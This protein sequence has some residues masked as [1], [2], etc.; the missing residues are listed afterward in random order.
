M[1]S[2][3]KACFTYYRTVLSML[4]LFIVFGFYAF[5]TMPKESAPDVKI[6]LISV[7]VNYEGISPQD[8]ERL[9]LRPLE[10][11]LRGLEGVQ[12]LKSYAFE[13][14][15]RVLIKFKAGFDAD[16]ALREARDKSED[17][18]PDLPQDSDRPTVSEINI[19]LFPVL[20]VNL[21]GEVPRR[22]LYEKARELQDAIESEIPAVLEAS[23]RGD[24]E[25]VAEILVDPLA[26]EGYKIS[27]VDVYNVLARNNKL[28]PAGFMD[29]GKGRIGIK[30]P[31]LI[32]SVDQLLN[33]PILHDTKGVVRIKDVAEIRDSFKD[34]DGYARSNGKDAVTLEVSKRTGENI[35]ETVA[36]VK[37]LVTQVTAKWPDNLRV[38]FTQD[39]SVQVKNLLSDLQNNVIAALILVIAVMVVTLGPQS[40][41]LVGIAVPGSFL[42]GV[43]VIYLMGYTLN[44]V[45]LF[46][47]ILSVGI[48]VDGAI[49]VVEY[50]DRKISE[51]LS[52]ADAYLA[53]AQRMFVPVLSS[54]ITVLIVFFPLMFWPGFV[55]QF[56]K[57]L[58]ITLIAVL[59][60][61][62]LMAIIFVPTI[63][64]LMHKIG[65]HP[66]L[67][68]AESIKAL[69]AGDLS[70]ADTLTAW[71]VRVL[72]KALDRPWQTLGWGMLSLV[73]VLML[74]GRFGK[75]I[76][77]F[78]TIEPDQVLV[79]VKARGNYSVREKDKLVRGVEQKIFA[80]KP[81]I[82]T[83]YT[84]TCLTR[85]G[86]KRGSRKPQQITED[87]IGLITLELADWRHRRSAEDIIK[88]LARDLKSFAGLDIEIEKEK[89]GPPTGKSVQIQISS[90]IPQAMEGVVHAVKA[91][92]R[93]MRSLLSHSD[94]L[95]LPGYDWGIRVDREEALKYGADVQT[96][97]SAVR[98]VTNGVKVSSYR[99]DSARDEI[100]IVVRY[101]RIYRNLDQ[102][103]RLRVKT[104]Q[105]LVPISYFTTSNPIPKVTTLR[106]VDGKRAVTLEA[107]VRFGVLASDV[108]HELRVWIAQQPFHKAVQITFKGDQEDQAETGAF[109]VKAFVI[110]LFAMMLVLVT[111]FNSFFS[112]GLILSA[113]MMSSVGVFV[114]L[115]VMNLPFSVV[116]C[117]IGLIALA[118]IIVSNNILLIDTFDGLYAPGK[119][120][121][122]TLLLTGAQRLRPVLLTQITTALGLLPIMLRINIDFLGREITFNAPSSHWWVQLST[123]IVFGIVFASPL[124][125]LMTPCALYLKKKRKKT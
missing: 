43:F 87:T 19:S 51:G 124:T 89:K 9:L 114:G 75:G 30:V 7:D 22:T 84:N 59:S 74:Y 97:G 21:F 63:G 25:R 50:A 118:G 108:I 66:G 78:P 31:G 46:S 68:N 120:L 67:K 123:A 36:Q 115:L 1:G 90:E 38:S 12:E 73:V 27:P 119:D 4:A 47:L 110:A 52:Y 81:D 96:V 104:D 20:V 18:I 121:R 80:Y 83:I 102:L 72:D 23:I 13:G 56:M 24:Q 58:P 45:V 65:F 53:A 109:L 44:I 15:G 11:K 100:D 82:D 8:S 26:L 93:E 70:Q 16:K 107:D 95:P 6:P 48:L 99:P 57:F 111:Q 5:M 55:G 61:S 106:R 62:L 32:E 116:M 40:S 10:Q 17:V 112:A 33:M 69:E 113:I 49:I 71:Y 105:G 85:A 88:S 39:G 3:I 77:F 79:K 101:P 54:T 92:L 91:H 122:K 60:A 37:S 28:V 29:T 64:S 42:M 86:K 125:L 2:V 34:L 35:L 76:E 41:L 103:E 14:G 117:G 98:L 94:D